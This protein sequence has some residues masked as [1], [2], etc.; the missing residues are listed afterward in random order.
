MIIFLFAH[1]ICYVPV[2]I[3]LALSDM[4]THLSPLI[5]LSYH[6]FYQIFCFP[7]DL[8]PTVSSPPD[9]AGHCGSPSPLQSWTLWLATLVY[10]FPML[11]AWLDDPM[12]FSYF[13]SSFVG[14]GAK[15]INSFSSYTSENSFI[16]L[17]H[18]V[19]AMGN[20]EVE[21]FFLIFEGVVLLSFKTQF[22]YWELWCNSN[23]FVTWFFFFLYFLWRFSGYFICNV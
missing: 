2:N 3:P 10:C 9:L 14:K 21:H 12:S 16:L 8:S 1:L 6:V 4:P 20:I 11:V 19:Y 18:V 13:Y 22:C 15:G 17:S 5:C 23:M 7:G